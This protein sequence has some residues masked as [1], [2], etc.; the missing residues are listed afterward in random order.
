LF[1]AASTIKECIIRDWCLLQPSD[2]ESMLSF[3]MHYVTH[4]IV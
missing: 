4:N 1:Q 2:I 3:L